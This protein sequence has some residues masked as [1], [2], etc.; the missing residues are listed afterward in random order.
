MKLLEK[1]RVYIWYGV[2]VLLFKFLN[3]EVPLEIWLAVAVTFCIDLIIVYGDGFVRESS[4][5]IKR[6][7]DRLHK[8]R[9]KIRRVIRSKDAYTQWLDEEEFLRYLEQKEQSEQNKEPTDNEA[10]IK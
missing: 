1:I 7:R 8:I 9:Q 4:L 2:V 5:I 10:N 6:G 3:I